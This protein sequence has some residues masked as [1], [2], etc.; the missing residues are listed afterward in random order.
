M[1]AAVIKVSSKGQIVIPAS[2]RKK[3]DI[4]EGD[5][6]LAVGDDEYLMIKKIEA[7]SLKQEFDNTVGP[8][9]RKIKKLGL[10]KEDLIEAIDAVR[11]EE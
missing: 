11:S 6:L 7:S 9:R 4:K 8:L 1:E 3:M 2:W 5:E 10:T